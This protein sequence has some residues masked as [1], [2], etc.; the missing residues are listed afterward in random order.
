MFR[1]IINVETSQKMNEIILAAEV[2]TGKRVFLIEFELNL[3]KK[4]CKGKIQLGENIENFAAVFAQKKMH[5]VLVEKVAP[6]S[7]FNAFFLEEGVVKIFDYSCLEN[8]VWMFGKSFNHRWI[9]P[10]FDCDFFINCDHI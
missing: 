1:T 8:L 4:E 6:R 10:P 5:F 2:L 7:C 3:R 9:G